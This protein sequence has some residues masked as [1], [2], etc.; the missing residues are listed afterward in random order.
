[1]PLVVQR[2]QGTVR[3]AAHGAAAVL[4]AVL[5]A[6]VAGESLP[7]SDR[8]AGTLGIEPLTPVSGAA[9]DVWV[10]LANHPVTLVAA[11]I[12]AAA[13][14]L[15]PWA[16]RSTLGVAAVGL[17]LVGSAVLAGAGV[18]STVVCAS[19]WAAAGISNVVLRRSS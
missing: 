1:M 10:W 4:S 3:R 17:V 8:A 5:L 15:L 14:A 18:A 13:S 9:S 2:A 19:V 11:A 12:V 6:A 16:R 7:V